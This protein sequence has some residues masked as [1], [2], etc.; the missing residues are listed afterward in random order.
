MP[1]AG[2]AK[3]FPHAFHKL[4]FTR[5]FPEAKENRTVAAARPPLQIDIVPK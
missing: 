4:I 5:I 1:C 2:R 3:F